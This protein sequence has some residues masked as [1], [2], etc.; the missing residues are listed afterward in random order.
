MICKTAYC[1]RYW[2]KSVHTTSKKQIWWLEWGSQQSTYKKTDLT[3]NNLTVVEKI[4]RYGSIFDAEI[5]QVVEKLYGKQLSNYAVMWISLLTGAANIFD[6]EAY[7]RCARYVHFIFMFASIYFC[8]LFW[9]SKLCFSTLAFDQGI[10][11][12][13]YKSTL[14]Y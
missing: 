11:S 2:L 5:A 6:L 8:K 12:P 9:Q 4:S 7:A 10:I 3:S 1:M 14:V 13:V